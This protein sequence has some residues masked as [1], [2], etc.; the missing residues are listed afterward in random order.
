MQR[1]SAAR[2]RTAPTLAARWPARFVAFDV[3]QQDGEELLNRP[4]AERRALLEALFADH[5]LTA[6][7]T[8]CPMTTDLAKARE[9][10]EPWTPTSPAS[11]ASWSKP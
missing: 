9:W 10:L 2:G 4:Y 1:R 6:P 7:W 8:L 3:L 5:R 11:R